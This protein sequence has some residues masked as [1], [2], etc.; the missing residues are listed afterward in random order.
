[1]GRG[2]VAV[3]VVVLSLFVGGPV[4]VGGEDDG[5][6]GCE[7]IFSELQHADAGVVGEDGE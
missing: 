3:E 5:L 2:S 7:L 1:M 6:L 4:G